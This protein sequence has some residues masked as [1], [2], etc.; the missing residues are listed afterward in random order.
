MRRSAGMSRTSCQSPWSCLLHLIMK[1]RE[2]R[3]GEQV[4]FSVQYTRTIR[5]RRCHFH[6]NRLP[7]TYLNGIAHCG[8]LRPKLVFQHIRHNAE[9]LG[10]GSFVRRIS[11]MTQ[12]WLC[13]WKLSRL[14]KSSISP[15]KRLK[16]KKER[17]FVQGVFHWQLGFGFPIKPLKLIAIRHEDNPAVCH[18]NG[19]GFSVRLNISEISWQWCGHSLCLPNCMPFRGIQNQK[20]R[21]LQSAACPMV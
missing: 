18:R 5:S 7:K 6:T 16:A 11:K 10:L 14:S 9:W 8:N 1:A 15:Y 3:P 20:P 19:E 12:Y 2:S 21:R 4:L 13:E 17:Y